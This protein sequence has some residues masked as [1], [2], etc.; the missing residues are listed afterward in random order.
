[1]IAQASGDPDRARLF[2]AQAR[3]INPYLMKGVRSD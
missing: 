3:A 2:F 1:M